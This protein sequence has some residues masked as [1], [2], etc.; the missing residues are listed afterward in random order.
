MTVQSDK[1]RE[2]FLAALKVP[3]GERDAF[4]R[5]ACAGADELCERVKLLIQAHE[6]LGS[7]AA[8]S[9]EA[10]VGPTID[11]P[12]A[13]TAGTVIGPYKLLEQIGE[14]GMGVVWMAEQTHPV[15]R[16]VAL[17]VVKPGMDSRQVIARFE[18]ERQALAMMD[19]VNIAR[20]LDAGATESGLPYFVMELV[21]GVP[22]TRYCDDNRLTP[23]ERLE[24]F[25]PVC[26]AI[27]H[28]HQKGIIHRDLKPSNVL[29]ASYD[30]RPVPR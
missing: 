15:Q 17:K 16:K 21:H 26:Q 1:L 25:V 12:M 20:V 6:E 24:L 7:I 3:D 27:Q 10:E 11:Q 13:E 5:Q 9:A 30:G 2:L 23:R 4:L 28:A 22:I 18:A 29:V 19:H 14:G 8:P